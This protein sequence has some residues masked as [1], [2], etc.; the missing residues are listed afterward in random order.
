V[1]AGHK[2]LTVDNSNWGRKMWMREDKLP[3]AIDKSTS[4]WA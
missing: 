3:S 4:L 1:P 2:R